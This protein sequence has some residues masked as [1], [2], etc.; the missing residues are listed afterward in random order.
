MHAFPP[1]SRPKSDTL[2]HCRAPRCNLI[3]HQHQ[4]I[5]PPSAP[6]SKYHI[7]LLSVF[8]CSCSGIAFVASVACFFLFLAAPARLST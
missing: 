8:F 3:A 6:L 4:L 5:T 7:L 2:S 1:M